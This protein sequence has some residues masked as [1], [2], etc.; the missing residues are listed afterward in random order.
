MTWRRIRKATVLVVLYKIADK[1]YLRLAIHLI[2]LVE[3][4]QRH[5]KREEA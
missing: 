2:L 1:L 4:L 5:V 3:W